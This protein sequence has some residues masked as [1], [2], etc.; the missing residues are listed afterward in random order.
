MK[1]YIPTKKIFL[2]ISKVTVELYSFLSSGEQRDI[3]KLIMTSG[4]LDEFT[5]IEE[6]K[7][8][9]KT[10][11]SK[12]DNKALLAIFDMQDTT[13]RLSFCSAKDEAG[14]EIQMENPTQFL[15]DLHP[16]DGEVLYLEIQEV[17]NGSSLNEEQKKN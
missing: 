3:Q 4:A 5:K 7:K 15:R 6:N 1:N 16:K 14:N 11:I 9:G 10:D 2:P 12:I 8:Q 17:M 13:F